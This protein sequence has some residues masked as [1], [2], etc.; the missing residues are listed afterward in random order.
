MRAAYTDCCSILSRFYQD[1]N[2][3]IGD[4]FRVIFGL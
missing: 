4:A 3:A 2:I 1:F